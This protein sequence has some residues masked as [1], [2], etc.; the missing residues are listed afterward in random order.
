M[1]I[2]NVEEGEYTD[3]KDALDKIL[4][5]KLQEESVGKHKEIVQMVSDDY[6]SWNK[7]KEHLLANPS[8]FKDQLKVCENSLRN[9]PKSYQAW[10]HR[11]F[12]MK[13]FQVQREK[14]LDRED[15]LTKLLLESDPRNFHC[16][17]YRM[18][19]LNT[20]P[21][22]DLFNYSYLHHSCSE[23]PL[24]IIYTDPLDPTCW[25]YFYL[26]RER[27]RMENGLYIRGYR[28]RLEIRF[29]KPFCGEITFEAGNTRKTIV[30]E[31]Y[32][33]IVAVE[34]VAE[35]LERCRVVMNGRA[36]DF[37]PGNEDFRFVHEILELEPECLGALLTLLD[38]TREEAKRA[39]MI[40]RIIRLDP[41]RRNH[42]NTLRGKFYSV[43]VPEIAL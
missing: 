35:A 17:N 5:L 20:R 34:G 36:V 43:Y 24:S 37:S 10:Y 32:T 25:E 11:K 13:S 39:D 4:K 22:R 27:K 29:S 30:S 3:D 38:Y 41:I 15:F 1:I 18:A 6:F 23:D 14:Y 12:M 8:D 16:W 9:D 26:W 40:E 28:G 31:L 7:L 33:R 21:V 42:Y 19:I 2:H